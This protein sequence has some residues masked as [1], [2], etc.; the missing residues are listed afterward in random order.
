MSYTLTSEVQI[1]PYMLMI[2]LQIMSHTLSN[3]P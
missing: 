1:M 3:D 2:E